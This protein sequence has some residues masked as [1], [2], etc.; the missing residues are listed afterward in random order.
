MEQDSSR[1]LRRS[2]RAPLGS[3]QLLDSPFR[4]NQARNTAYLMFLDL[5]RMLR[6]FKINYG[7]PTTASPAAAGRNPPPRSAAT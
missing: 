1:L 2:R 6:P 7:V 5:D 3:V 4:A